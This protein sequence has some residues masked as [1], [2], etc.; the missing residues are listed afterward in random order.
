MGGNIDVK[1]LIKNVS[2]IQDKIKEI[3]FEH[4][5]KANIESNAKSSANFK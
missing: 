5:L 1:S 2:E 4:Y 3:A